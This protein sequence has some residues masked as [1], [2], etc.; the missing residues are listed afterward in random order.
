M[1]LKVFSKGEGK[2]GTVSCLPCSGLLEPFR[3]SLAQSSFLGTSEVCLPTET[4]SPMDLERTGVV[5]RVLV[6]INLGCKLELPERAVKTL[7]P[8]SWAEMQI[9]L[10]GGVALRWQAQGDVT[11]SQGWKPP[12]HGSHSSCASFSVVNRSHQ[13]SIYCVTEDEVKFL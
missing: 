8:N 13:L 1:S 12:T 7:T 10:F 6:T 9:W 3:D 2:A 11:C 4:W 5:G